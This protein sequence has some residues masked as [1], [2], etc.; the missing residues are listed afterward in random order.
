MRPT[1]CTA[2]PIGLLIANEYY[3]I[4]KPLRDA[5]KGI[6]FRSVRATT[7]AQTMREICRA[8]EID[9]DPDA[10]MLIAERAGGDMRSAINDLQAAAEGQAAVAVADV[11]TA[12]RDV[13]S[14]I[15]KV[16]EVIFKGSRATEA[17]AASYELDES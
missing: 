11:A 12:E 17:L 3:E 7:I 15:F 13:K 6:Q 5:A 8:E 1:I 9:C 4:E 16:L 10:L 2:L 14:S